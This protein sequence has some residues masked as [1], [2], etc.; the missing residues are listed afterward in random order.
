MPSLSDRV[1][2]VTGAGSG[3][4]RAIALA[5]SENGARVVCSDIRKSANSGGF[6]ADIAID[7]DEVI[8]SRGGQAAYVSCDVT[9]GEDVRR[10]ADQAVREFGRIDIWVNNAGIFTKL[11]TIIDQSE[12]DFDL[13]MAV[14]TKGAWLGCKYAIAQMMKQTP[15]PSGV[16]GRIINIASVAALSGVPQESAYCT[17]KG[18]VTSMTRQLAIDFGKQGINVN[19]IMPGVIKTAMTRAYLDEP[20]VSARF[21]DLTPFMRI[22]EASDVASATV[23]LASDEAS[24]VTGISLPVDGG[25]LAI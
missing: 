2:V 15:P 17:S 21:H 3:M 10:L 23:F 22:G 8:R 4:G 16:R 11:E 18:A 14:N 5:L 9:K 24:F 25:L 12:E 20:D 6:E 19:A 7:T 1:A 13:T